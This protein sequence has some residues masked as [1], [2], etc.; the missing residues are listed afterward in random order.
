MLKHVDTSLGESAGSQERPR[1]AERAR[2]R[3]GAK[4]CLH[5]LARVAAHFM[6]KIRPMEEHD[7]QL[8]G[9]PPSEIAEAGAH[10]KKE[11]ELW[12]PSR[13]SR[14]PNFSRPSQNGCRSRTWIWQLCA[15]STRGCMCAA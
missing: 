5:P 15:T 10:G 14:W 6:S 13:P 9:E 11:E 2:V 12:S 8:G 3:Q 1:D 7:G 4:T